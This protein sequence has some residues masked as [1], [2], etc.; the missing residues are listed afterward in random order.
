MR[1]QTEAVLAQLSQIQDMKGVIEDNR[2]LHTYWFEY[3]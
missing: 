1:P 3:S 2:P